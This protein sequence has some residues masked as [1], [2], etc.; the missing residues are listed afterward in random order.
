MGK[1]EEAFVNTYMKLQS[2]P[3]MLRVSML[4]QNTEV[5]VVISTP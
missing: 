4:P 5:G 1:L 2:F 3:D